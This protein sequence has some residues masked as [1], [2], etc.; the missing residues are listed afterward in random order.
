MVRACYLG[1]DC[2]HENAMFT[3]NSKVFTSNY[4]GVLFLMKL[5][6]EQL[7]INW[8]LF[9]KEEERKPRKKPFSTFP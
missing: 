5:L 3:D 4:A 1:R 6:E 2:H 8:V 9:K 7:S